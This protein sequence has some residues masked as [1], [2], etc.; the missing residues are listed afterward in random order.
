MEVTEFPTPTS[1]KLTPLRGWMYGAVVRASF[2]RLLTFF[3]DPQA[4]PFL[5]EFFQVSCP[6]FHF[7]VSL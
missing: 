1:A 2:S 6:L 7:Y 5:S 3:I 4:L